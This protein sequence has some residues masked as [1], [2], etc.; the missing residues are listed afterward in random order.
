MRIF[1][2]LLLLTGVTV[3]L[4]S[5]PDDLSQGAAQPTPMVSTPSLIGSATMAVADV[6]AFCT[7]QPGVC[8]TA[9]NVAAHLEAKAKYNVRLLYEWANEP[10]SETAAPAP[11]AADADPMST[12]SSTVIHKRE[13]ASQSTLKLEDL[14]PPWRG[15][16]ATKKS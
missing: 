1:R 4:P 3:F 16:V 7:R 8:Q 11:V 13:L 9:G 10:G 14:I 12:G 5:P 2:T 6:A 15:P